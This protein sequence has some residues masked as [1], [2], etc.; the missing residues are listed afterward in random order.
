MTSCSGEMEHRASGWLL[1]GGS[2]DGSLQGA[3]SCG[4][5]WESRAVRLQCG[6]PLSPS[7]CPSPGF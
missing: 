4:T 3:A 1:P 6:A 7:T 5:D 2:G